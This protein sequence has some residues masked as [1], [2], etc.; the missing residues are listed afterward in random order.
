VDTW[1]SQTTLAFVPDVGILHVAF[2]SVKTTLVQGRMSEGLAGLTKLTVSVLEPCVPKFFPVMVI[3]MPPY[4][5]PVVGVTAVTSGGA[6]VKVAGATT[7][8]PPTVS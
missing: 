2:V 6:K 8:W 7:I 5:G 1:T 3:G 4:E